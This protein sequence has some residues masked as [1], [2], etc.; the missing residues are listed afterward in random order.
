MKQ[1]IR[2]A[3][4]ELHRKF[5]GH[6][7]APHARAAQTLSAPLFV[8]LLFRRA[9]SVLGPV[10]PGDKYWSCAL[11]DYGSPDDPVAFKTLLA[12]SPLH[13]G[14]GPP[15]GTRQY[16]AMLLTTGVLTYTTPLH[17]TF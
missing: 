13:T 10:T 9:C 7:Q 17:A 16:P 15:G 8:F 11:A 3:Q 4:Q 12:I 1:C 14:R 2:A 6:L 5:V